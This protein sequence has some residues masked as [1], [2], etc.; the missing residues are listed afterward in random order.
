MTAAPAIP[1]REAP[2]ILRDSA[3]WFE[4]GVLARRDARRTRRCVECS[5]ALPTSRTP[6]CSRMCQWKYHGRFFWDAA[7]IYVLRRDRYTCRQ[8]G[9]RSRRARLEVDHI[10]EIALG[11][12]SLDYGNLQTLCRACHRAKTVAFNRYRRGGP[13][14]TEGPSAPETGETGEWFPA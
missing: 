10:R 3:R 1:R 11:G 7:R 9:V 13:R 8:C 6:Y 4:D 2:R 5:A 14:W 12:P